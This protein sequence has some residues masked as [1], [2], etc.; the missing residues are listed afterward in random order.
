V[1]F[2]DALG[3]L[4]AENAVT[5]GQSVIWF[6]NAPA[7]VEYWDPQ[8]EPTLPE[9]L[10]EQARGVVHDAIGTRLL[11]GL[12]S[13]VSAGPRWSDA[14]G[15]ELIGSVNGGLLPVGRLPTAPRAAYAIPAGSAVDFLLRLRNL[16]RSLRFPVYAFLPLPG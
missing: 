7:Q 9:L 1:S 16:W 15:A 13:T 12:A 4:E 14:L 8:A 11:S 3:I 6:A 5:A 10:V 2:S